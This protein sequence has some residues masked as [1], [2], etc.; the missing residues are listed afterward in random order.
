MMRMEDSRPRFSQRHPL[1]FGVLMITMAVILFLGVTAFVRAMGW[2]SG[3][4]ALGKDSLGVVHIEGM[5]MDSTDVVDWINTL[6]RD[7]DVKGV[8]LRVNSPGG[9]IAPSQE[10]YEAVKM[11]AAEKPVVA[12]YAT[13]AAS[14]GYYASVPSQII[15][16]NPGSIT[17]SIGV[18]AEFITVTEAL[19]KLGIKPEVLTT[20]KYKAAGT[21]IRELT[22]EQ[23]AQLLGMMLDMH[24]Q[25][26]SDVAEARGMDRARIEEV[27]DGRAVTGRQ[28]L[29]LGL[30]DLL[31]SKQVAF[32]KLKTMCGI[33]GTAILVEGPIHEKTF[34]EEV[35]GSIQIDISGLTNSVGNWSFSYK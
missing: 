10:I 12:S 17:A 15:V 3:N 2:T 22:D 8:L 32:D 11:L 24:D 21:P 7:E 14:G 1:M 31:G 6:R 19:S 16:A 29:A 30:V 25:F 20:G 26:V 23:R 5:I 13:V 35:L 34:M 28:A 4:F 9:A 18:M 33:E 27:A